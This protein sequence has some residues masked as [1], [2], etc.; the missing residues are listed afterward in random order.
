MSSSSFPI[1]HIVD[2][3]DAVR[4]SLSMLLDSVGIANTPYSSALAFLNTLSG[5]DITQLAGCVVMD[6]RM[7][8]MSGMEC[9]QKLKDLQCTLPII[10]ITGHGDVPMAVEAM[11]HGALE[12]IQKPFREQEL[13]DCIHKALQNHQ[14]SQQESQYAKDI[15][16]RLALLSKRETEV[17]QRVIGGQAN[18]VIAI[19]LNLSQRTIEIHRANVMEKMQASSLAELVR[20]VLTQN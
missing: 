6:I 9:Q 17:M 11:K 16:A 15:K 19:E 4:D 18:K 10:F 12:F 13:L 20:M 5:K 3:D 1:V 7:P 14:Q 8:G 2:D